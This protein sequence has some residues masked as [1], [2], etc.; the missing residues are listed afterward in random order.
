VAGLTLT[1]GIVQIKPKQANEQSARD[2]DCDHILA[3]TELNLLNASDKGAS[4]RRSF[5]D[6]QPHSVS[7]PLCHRATNVV[8][9]L[10]PSAR[11]DSGMGQVTGLQFVIFTTSAFLRRSMNAMDVRSGPPSAE[12]QVTE[13][14]AQV[15]EPS[16]QI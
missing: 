2:T 3:P 7:T 5:C 16:R 8:A 15:I 1:C 13:P 10:Q 9:L 14:F 4:S 6:A 11:S 12:R